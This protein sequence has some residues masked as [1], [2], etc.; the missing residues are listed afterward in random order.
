MRLIDADRQIERVKNHNYCRMCRYSDDCYVAD[1][2]QI[3]C[4][5]YLIRDIEEQ[6][7][8][9]DVDKVCEELERVRRFYCDT[10]DFKVRMV[11]DCA[12][13]I[14]RRGGIDDND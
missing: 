5:K 7:I 2:E 10:D 11:L 9:Y 8:A 3:T 13:D 1:G 14:V 4:E 6:P 12:I